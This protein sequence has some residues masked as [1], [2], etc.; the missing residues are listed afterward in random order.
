MV[1]KFVSDGLFFGTKFSLIFKVIKLTYFS[2]K[3]YNM[4]FCKFIKNDMELISQH[5]LK[6]EGYF[7]Y[8]LVLRMNFFSLFFNNDTILVLI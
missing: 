7:S 2:A 6:L 3:D 1:C 4:F 5:Y 8:P